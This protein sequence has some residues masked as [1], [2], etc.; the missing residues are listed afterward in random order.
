MG[1]RARETVRHRRHGG[2]TTAYTYD[3]GD[4]PTKTIDSVCGTI[5]RTYDNRFDTATTVWLHQRLRIERTPLRDRSI[6]QPAFPRHFL[7]SKRRPRSSRSV[8]MRISFQIST[9]VPDNLP[10]DSVLR[11]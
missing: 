8:R 11:D 10:P 3:A 4:R 9:R 5:T 2:A 6:Q 7:E 1:R